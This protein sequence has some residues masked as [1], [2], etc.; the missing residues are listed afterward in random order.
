MDDARQ[1]APTQRELPRVLGFWS[2]TAVMM[3]I[4]IGS[5]IFKTPIDVANSIASPWAII[6]LWI[7]GGVLSLCGAFTFAEL[8]T[9][10]PQSG[11]VYVFLREGYGRAGR[12]I[13]FVFGWTYTLISKPTAAAAI[14]ALFGESVLPLIHWQSDDPA[15]DS[16]RAKLLT[17]VVLVVLTWVNV[18]GIRL[19]AGIAAVFTSVKV[20]ALLAI[21]AVAALAA[22]RHDPFASSPLANPQAWYL[23]V[24]LA[25]SGIMWTY[26]G[27][28][29]VG[30][31]AGEIKDPQRKLPLCYIAGT[32]IITAV[33]VG[34]NLAY[35]RMLPIDVI[36]S[37]SDIAPRALSEVLGSAAGV[38]ATVLVVVSTFGS[39]IGSIMTG[40][41]VTFAQARDGLFFSFFGRVDPKR[42]TPALALWIQLALSLTL[43]WTLKGFAEL[44]NSFVFTIW[45]FYG[46]A[47]AALFIL[48]RTRPDAPR[49]YRCWGYPLVPGFFVL[50]AA[51]MTVLSLW[52]D[53][54]SS[55]ETKAAP[56]TLVWL[57][58]LAAGVPVY[59][60]WERVRAV[61]TSADRPA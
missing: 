13:A 26:D 38:A 29:D 28:A 59:I 47:G 49:P 6:L 36:R 60:V 4:I 25:M 54:A 48:R 52:Q 11:G 42:E 56:M 46:L 57:G 27:W 5:G 16:F 24:V 1:S 18:R 30:A 39:T 20:V 37:E 19:G 31:L 34:V 2:V 61:R 51:A 7:A 23:A 21:I 44:A 43:L 55:M 40:A 45:I 35:F 33:Y 58:V 32:A 17:S 41:R 15:T 22:P 9:M 3:G 12:C 53:V 50:A 14:A 10:Y 8:A